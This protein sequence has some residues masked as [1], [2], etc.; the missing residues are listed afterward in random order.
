MDKASAYGAGDCRFESCRGHLRCAAARAAGNPRQPAKRH[1]GDSNPC[2]QSPMDFES[3][4]LTARTQCHSNTSENSQRQMPQQLLAPCKLSGRESG[5]DPPRD[6]WK[7]KPRCRHGIPRTQRCTSRAALRKGAKTR[8][9]QFDARSGTQCK[10][11]LRELNPGPL[12]PKPR[13]IPLD[14][15]AKRQR[16]ARN[17][18]QRRKPPRHRCATRRI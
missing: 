3:I 7:Y 18:E 14:Q 1:R 10:G 5:L 8:N 4:S 2:G 15:A 17:N 6:G 13:I 12:G 11:L 9:A 16:P